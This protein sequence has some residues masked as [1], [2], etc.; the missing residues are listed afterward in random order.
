MFLICLTILI[1][2]NLIYVE[3]QRK[4]IERRQTQ[5]QKHLVSLNE[6]IAE[7]K[8]KQDTISKQRSYNAEV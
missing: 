6:S 8:R 7:E 4:D 5:I 1:I 3:R 2:L